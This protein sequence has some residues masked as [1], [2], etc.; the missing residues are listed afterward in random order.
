M[1]KLNFQ[2]IRMEIYV[3]LPEEFLHFEYF[4]IPGKSKLVSAY[5]LDVFPYALSRH[6]QKLR[7]AEK[8]KENVPQNVCQIGKFLCKK[9]NNNL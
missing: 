3:W 8:I 2:E 4:L 9:I 1:T 7:V 5:D 6:N